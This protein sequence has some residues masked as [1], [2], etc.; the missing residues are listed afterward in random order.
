MPAYSQSTMRM[1]SPSRRKLA[2]SRSLWHGT[3]SWSGPG[4]TDW[5]RAAPAAAPREPAGSRTPRPRAA[6]G[7]AVGIAP[8]ALA[9]LVAVVNDQREGVEARVERRPA[10]DRAQRG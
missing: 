3:G 10:V 7:E 8:A 2:G 1:R 6:L 5:T 9:H 4:R